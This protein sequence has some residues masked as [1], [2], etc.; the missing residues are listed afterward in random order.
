MT[1]QTWSPTVAFD[2]RTNNRRVEIV[3]AKAPSKID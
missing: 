1:L 3:I 2:G